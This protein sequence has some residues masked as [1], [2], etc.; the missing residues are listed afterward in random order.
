LTD[1]RFQHAPLISITGV[2]ELDQLMAYRVVDAWFDAPVD[3]RGLTQTLEWLQ[4][5]EASTSMAA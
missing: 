2:D 5:A 3:L 4:A 1:Y